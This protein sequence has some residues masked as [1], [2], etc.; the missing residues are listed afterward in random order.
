MVE[1]TASS[2]G[3]SSDAPLTLISASP[4]RTSRAMPARDCVCEKSQCTTHAPRVWNM[5]FSSRSPRLSPR[6]STAKRAERAPPGGGV[7][8]QSTAAAAGAAGGC[9]VG[10][11]PMAR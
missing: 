6:N 2:V 5:F 9:A 7:K 4:G 3:S 1:M 10:G 11:D 8:A